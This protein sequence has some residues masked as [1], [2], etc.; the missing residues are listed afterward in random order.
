MA[1]RVVLTDK[2]EADV[3]CSTNIPLAPACS[4]GREPPEGRSRAARSHEVAKGRNRR[5]EPFDFEARE[6]RR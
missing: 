3:E 5:C 1:Y 2:A 6:A 4:R